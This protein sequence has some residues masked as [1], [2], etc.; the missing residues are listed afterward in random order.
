MANPICIDR[1]C[2]ACPVSNGKAVPG[3]GP[4]DLSKV[5]LIVISDHAGHYEEEV[6]QPFVSNDAKRM[7]KRLRNGKVSL[8][9]PR[10]AGSILRLCLNE[11]GLNPNRDVWLT[12]VMKCNPQQFKPTEKDA[13][14]CTR[15][16]LDTELTTLDKY[17]P[18]API[19]IAGNLA[20]KTIANVYKADCTYATQNL[21]MKNCWKTTG[22][23]LMSH[24]LFFTANP[25]A[26]AKCEWGYE[27]TVM[28]HNDGTVSPTSKG[29]L[30][31]LPLS[32]L[33]TFKKDLEMVR[34]YLNPD[35]DEEELF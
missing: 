5:K 27:R 6:G 18:N 30:P 17:V 10:N 12:N 1:E 8:E 15:K 35:G 7:T 13:K 3:A 34:Q 29:V 21:K 16:W 31:A 19:L 9:K 11:I 33:W 32:P 24:P 22:H 20:F 4:D 2:K 28:Q 23:K 14:T 25:A 26:V